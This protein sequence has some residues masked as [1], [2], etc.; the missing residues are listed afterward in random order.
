MR[1][2]EGLK[3]GGVQREGKKLKMHFASWKAYFSSCC[4]SITVLY[5]SQWDPLRKKEQ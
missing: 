5:L 4:F 2:L 3:I 1:K